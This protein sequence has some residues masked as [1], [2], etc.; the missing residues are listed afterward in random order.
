MSVV[1]VAVTAYFILTQSQQ[2][3]CTLPEYRDA[4]IFEDPSYGLRYYS[5]IDLSSKTNI[6]SK[7]SKAIIVVHGSQRNADDYYCGI[8][9]AAQIEGYQVTNQDI[10]IIAPR[11]ME[12]SDTP[13]SNELYW[14]GEEDSG[15]KGGGNSVVPKNNA[16][17]QVSSYGAVDT[18]ISL[19]FI[20]RA[21]LYP[22]L[23]NI[24]IVGHSAGGQFVQRYALTSPL[25]LNAT[26]DM[27]YVAANPSSFCYLDSRRW[28]NDEIYRELSANEQAAC[29][30]YNAWKYGWSESIIPNWKFPPYIN[31]QN[32]TFDQVKARYKIRNVTYLHGTNDV[33]N[34]ELN[35]TCQDGGLD[36][37]CQADLQGVFR[38][39]RGINFLRSLME[40]Y[41]TYIHRID[42]V[43]FV[44][45]DH[46]DMF[47]HPNGRRA[48]F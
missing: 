39:E 40:I 29:P 12:E 48:I 4:F 19:L 33:C 45:H 3:N 13:N 42:F 30:G 15:W 44:G 21:D 20:E 26:Y 6:I 16:D 22:N 31:D 11:F 37:S 25:T 32:I 14:T 35:A 23:K 8:F 28:F 38:L 5:N 36:T 46:V 34:H 7:P 24:T 41:G 1:L 10:I 27:K 2:Q 47:Q 43:P 9:V 18:L 17:N